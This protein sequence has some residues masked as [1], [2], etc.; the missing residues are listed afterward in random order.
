MSWTSTLISK[1]NIVPG[2]PLK[3]YQACHYEPNACFK[4][5]PKL[6]IHWVLMNWTHDCGSGAECSIINEQHSMSM[7]CSWNTSIA[8]SSQ[9]HARHTLTESFLS[10]L[11]FEFM[12]CMEMTLQYSTFAGH[13][14]IL[15]HNS[16]R[17]LSNKE[18]TRHRFLRCKN[19][20][21]WQNNLC[22][23]SNL[24]SLNALKW[25]CP[26]VVVPVITEYLTTTQWKC[27]VQ[28]NAFWIGFSITN[29]THFDRINFVRTQILVH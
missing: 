20:T 12:L 1:S 28:Q 25:L 6:K 26:A 7:M 27:C 17:M 14:R 15:G 19:D 18:Y 3:N 29:T 2:V 22:H 16:M 11:K 23:N 9:K 5:F 24:S 8:S 21:L 13:Y 10:E 4:F